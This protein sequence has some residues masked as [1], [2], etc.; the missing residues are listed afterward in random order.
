MVDGQT[1]TIAQSGRASI[2]VGTP[3]LDHNGPLG[4]RGRYFTGS[5][6]EHIDFFFHYS[7][8]DAYFQIGVTP[9]KVFHFRHAPKRRGGALVWDQTFGGRRAA[10]SVNCPPPPPSGPLGG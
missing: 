2:A 3:Q 9:A 6:T 5:F 4:C 1:I 8:R 7:S 10:V